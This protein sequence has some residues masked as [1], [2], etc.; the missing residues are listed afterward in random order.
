MGGKVGISDKTGWPH[1]NNHNWNHNQAA[2]P[3]AMTTS[4]A[5]SRKSWIECAPASVWPSIAI[6]L[7]LAET[8]IRLTTFDYL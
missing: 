1:S 3:I 5:S 2:E 7:V 6:V 4:I 8:T